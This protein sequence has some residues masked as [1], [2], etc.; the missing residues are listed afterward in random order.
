MGRRLRGEGAPPL[1]GRGP[2]RRP[3]TGRHRP[4]PSLLAGRVGRGRGD[5]A[6]LR[7]GSCGAVGDLSGGEGCGAVGG[8]GARRRPHGSSRARRRRLRS[9]DGRAGIDIFLQ[10]GGFPATVADLESDEFLAQTP[11]YFGGQAINE[12][13]VEASRTVS[14]GWQYLPFQV[15]ANSVFPDT[16]GQSFV[17]HED[18]G[19]G[20]MDWQDQLVEYG[21]QQG[22]SVNK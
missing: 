13:L 3:G 15:Y 6:P 12:I 5:P 19:S 10:S 14:T 11:E 1:R 18:I 4:R 21:D 9:E 22:F 2:R 8:T 17:N 20:L 7:R 16:V